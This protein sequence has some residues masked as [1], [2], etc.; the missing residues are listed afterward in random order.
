MVFNHSKLSFDQ[1][2]KI[3]PHRL[4]QV[5]FQQTQTT[6]HL[7]SVTKK[8]ALEKIHSDSLIWI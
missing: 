1:A 6:Q 8:T 7:V 4:D 5:K 3:P 2:K